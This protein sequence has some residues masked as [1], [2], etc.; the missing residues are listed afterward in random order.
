MVA[1]GNS[2]KP[3]IWKQQNKLHKTGRHRS[4]GQ[5]GAQNKGEACWF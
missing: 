2:H 5:L 3:G 1:T 4:K